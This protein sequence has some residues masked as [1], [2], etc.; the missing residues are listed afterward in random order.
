MIGEYRPIRIDQD[1]PFHDLAQKYVVEFDDSDEIS[2]LQAA[3]ATNF[4][5][6]IISSDRDLEDITRKGSLIASQLIIT[7]D[8]SWPETTVG[9]DVVGGQTFR[10]EINKQMRSPRLAT[11]GRWLRDVA[12]LIEAKQLVY[13]PNISHELAGGES[14]PGEPVKAEELGLREPRFHYGLILDGGRLTQSSDL[15]SLGNRAMIR[16]LDIEIPVLEG[17]RLRDFSVI[18]VEE[19]DAHGVFRDY[20]RK[21]LLDLDGL[22]DAREVERKSAIIGIELTE[23]LRELTSELKLVSKRNAVQATGATLTFASASLVAV[24]SP[25]LAP[26]LLALGIAGGAASLAGALT[27]LQNDTAKLHG[28]PFYFLWLLRHK[29]RA[30]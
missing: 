4:N 5:V 16:L 26:V 17:I 23:G 20:L 21:R 3:L 22:S 13:V 25:A 28:R 24:T 19:S 7:H 12:P 29:V 6:S 1:L 10:W 9:T 11:L 15:A 30:A 18:T 2:N 8:D 14:N 27:N